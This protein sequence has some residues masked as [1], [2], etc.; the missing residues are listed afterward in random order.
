MPIPGG[1]GEGFFERGAGGVGGARPGLT[2]PTP[3]GHQTGQKPRNKTPRLSPAPPPPQH[4]TLT[5][6]WGGGPLQNVTNQFLCTAWL[7][8]KWAYMKGCTPKKTEPPKV[9][10]EKMRNKAGEEISRGNVHLA[11]QAHRPPTK[12]KKNTNMTNSRLTAFRPMGLRPLELT[13]GFIAGP[14]RNIAGL[15]RSGTNPSPPK[16]NPLVW[17]SVP[18]PG[19]GGA[20]R[21]WLRG[22]AVD[23][24]VLLHHLLGRSHRA[25]HRSSWFAPPPGSGG[26][27]VQLPSRLEWAGP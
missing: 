22:R 3:T 5:T 4:Q 24:V 19:S 11:L 14:A 8:N 9:T 1:L 16:R 2:H 17:R 10:W 7:Q 26:G 23:P 6:C 12:Q 21:S 20:M 25:V 27:A 13:T 18:E 15:G